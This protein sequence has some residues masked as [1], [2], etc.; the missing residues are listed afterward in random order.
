MSATSSDL[1]QVLDALRQRWG[2]DVLRP[3]SH[4]AADASLPSGFPA[5][6]AVLSRGGVPCGGITQLLGQPTSGMVTLALHILARA[7]AAGYAAIAID[8]TRTLDLD[9][10]RRCGVILDRLVLV[11]PHP[12]TAGLEI[13]RDVVAH[14]IPAVFLFDATSLDASPEAVARIARSLRRLKAALVTS[15]CI[16]L[17]L[18]PAADHAC[19]AVI[20]PVAAVQLHI[21]RGHW[22]HRTRD[23]TG[24]ETSVTVL[25]DQH[26]RPGQ[27]ATITI[28]LDSDAEDVCP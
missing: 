24:Y 10:A 3:L 22:L 8:L 4:L 21:R 6:D 15:P 11:W 17:C 2:A 23:V 25:K 18:T 9:Y 13:A 27:S 1:Q 7:Q 14:D 20:S 28:R 26:G 16:F 12:A 5:L 19:S